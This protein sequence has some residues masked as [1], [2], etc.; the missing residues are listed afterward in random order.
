MK[1]LIHLLQTLL[2]IA[3]SSLAI[4]GVFCGIQWLLSLAHVCDAPTWIRFFGGAAGLAILF[5]V[6]G[7]RGVMKHFKGQ[8]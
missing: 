8:R 6:L 7:L 3:G 5:V 1:N 2:M 4:S